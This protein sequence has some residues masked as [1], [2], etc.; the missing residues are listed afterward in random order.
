MNGS[1][2]LWIVLG[3]VALII[4]A[5]V[6]YFA[7][8]KEADTRRRETSLRGQSHSQSDTVKRRG[9]STSDTPDS[10]SPMTRETDATTHDESSHDEQTRVRRLDKRD[11]DDRPRE[12]D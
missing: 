5:A 7:T 6:V 2:T 3:I 12:R 8:R 9:K 11:P 10:R 4:I 1:T